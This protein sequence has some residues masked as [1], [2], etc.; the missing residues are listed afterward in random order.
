MPLSLRANKR[1]KDIAYNLLGV[2]ANLKDKPT[3]KQKK[4][5]KRLISLDTAF[6]K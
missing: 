2:P 3:M 6:V 1:G 5:D 4:V